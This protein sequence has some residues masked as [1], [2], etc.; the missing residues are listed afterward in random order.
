MTGLCRAAGR[1]RRWLA[2]LAL[3]ALLGPVLPALAGPEIH[4]LVAGINDYAYVPRLQ[5]PVNDA[6][7]IAK[8]FEQA[9]A[10]VHLLL[11]AQVTKSRLRSQ[12][13]SMMQEAPAGSLLVFYYAGHS[14]DAKDTSPHPFRPRYDYLV[15]SGFHKESREH[16]ELQPDQFLTGSELR[17]WFVEAARFRLLAVI[18]SCT[19]SEMYRSSQADRLAVPRAMPRYTE[20]GPEATTP[21]VASTPE[22]HGDPKVLPN[23]L[24]ISAAP[25][26]VT[27]DDMAI[28]TEYR[29]ALSFYFAKALRGEAPHKGRGLSIGDLFDYLNTSVHRITDDAQN[30]FFLMGSDLATDDLLFT[31]P[32]AAPP[33]AAPPASAADLPEIAVRVAPDT[34]PA[35]LKQLQGVTP[36]S[37]DRPALLQIDLAGHGVSNQRGER[38]AEADDLGTM[39]HVIYKWRHIVA[40][41]RLA[42]RRSQSMHLALNPAQARQKADVP[43]LYKGE[44]VGIVVSGL[45]ADRQAA[46]FDLTSLGTLQLLYPLTEQ[47]A[48]QPRPDGL[49]YVPAMADIPYGADHVIAITSDDPRAMKLFTAQLRARYGVHGNGVLSPDDG[50]MHLVGQLPGLQVGIQ[51]VYTCD[52]VK[53]CAK[54]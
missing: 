42:D 32:A 43:W 6:Q 20:V 16:P 13:L 25:H 46:V 7:D 40:L 8:A 47:D 33:A 19:S 30:I 9:G 22:P 38:V 53:K 14:A 15:F 44:S 52:S 11:N 17:A 12:W 5:G 4:V 26:G 48:A 3:V 45:S 41:N 10:H 23:Q 51:S 29:G 35:I 31:P 21:V 27:V 36:A 28:G 37:P 50:F 49:L 24:F 39:Q 2:G 54:P 1:A 18:D 34:D